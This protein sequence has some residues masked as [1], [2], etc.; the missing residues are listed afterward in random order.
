MGVDVHMRT[1][2]LSLF[3]PFAPFTE[4]ATRAASVKASL[5]PR[6]LF[7]EHS[8]RDVSTVPLIAISP[9]LSCTEIPKGLDSPGHL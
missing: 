7:A 9:L 6:F 8:K 1:H 5:T 3:A 4:S 2:L